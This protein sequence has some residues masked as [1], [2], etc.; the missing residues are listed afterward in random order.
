MLNGIINAYENKTGTPAKPLQI[1]DISTALREAIE[2]HKEKVL[3]GLNGMTEEEFEQRVAEFD[4]LYTPPPDATEGQKQIFEIRRADFIVNLRKLQN[5]KTESLI[6]HGKTEEE[7][8][9]GYMQSKI[10]CN[11]ALQQQ[12]NQVN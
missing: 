7:D 10:P 1:L 2:A 3:S 6:N 9:M 12:L 11:P 4:A 8:T 5:L